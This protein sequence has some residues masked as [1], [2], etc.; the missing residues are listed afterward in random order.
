MGGACS[1]Y[2][3]RRGAY[4]VLWG[5]LRDSDHFEDTGVD[6]KKFKMDLWVAW[7]GLIWLRIGTG[8]SSWKRGSEPS[9]SVKS[10]EFLVGIIRILEVYVVEMGLLEPYGMCSVSG[11]TWLGIRCS[12]N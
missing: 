3:E 9:G 12:G 7:T 2:G 11:M 4:R 10:G 6:R 1:T 8:G 5:N